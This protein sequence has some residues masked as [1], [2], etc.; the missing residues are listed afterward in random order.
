MFAMRLGF[1][2]V[3][4]VV[5]LLSVVFLAETVRAQAVATV[6]KPDDNAYAERVKKEAQKGV[7]LL[8]DGRYEDALRAF[9][10]C[11]MY[12]RAKIL[13]ENNPKSVGRVHIVDRSPYAIRKTSYQQDGLAPFANPNEA[14]DYVRLLQ[15]TMAHGDKAGC[16]DLLAKIERLIPEDPRI[17]WMQRAIAYMP[18]PKNLMAL[19]L[20]DGVELE[21]VLIR[22]GSFTMGAAD[23]DPGEKPPH[24]V[25]ISKPFH[26]GKYKVTQKQWETIMGNNPSFYKGPRNP[27]E[28]VNWNECQEF[29]DRMNKKFADRGI[30]FGLPTSAQREYACRAGSTT[31]FHF[32]DYDSQLHHY[33]WF[34]LNSDGRTHPVGEKKP[35]AWGL[36]DMHGNTWEICTDHYGR[37]NYYA[38]SPP[39][40][41]PGASSGWARVLRGGSY[42]ASVARCRSASRFPGNPNMSI[43]N[44][45]LRLICTTTEKK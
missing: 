9:N 22:P 8:I 34:S 2:T 40:D 4:C 29:I 24:R 42:S 37:G 21:M 32:G 17:I 28:S 43:K 5:V 11:V 44:C 25:T 6:K 10:R 26:I 3:L 45:G 19:Y 31:R 39:I 12:S 16:E 35:N 20:G 13:F 14:E 27:V 1:R 38:Q 33:A 36:Y 23:G 30:E 41:P 7:Q 18:G 15:S